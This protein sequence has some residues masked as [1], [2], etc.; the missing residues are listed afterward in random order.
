MSVPHLYTYACTCTHVCMHRYIC[1]LPIPPFFLKKHKSGKQSTFLVFRR[2]D[3]WNLCSSRK[4]QV[5]RLS[6]GGGVNHF[7]HFT[8]NGIW[9]FP[10]KRNPVMQCERPFNT[11]RLLSCFII[12]VY[13]DEF[14]KKKIP[15]SLVQSAT[16]DIALGCFLCLWVIEPCSCMGHYVLFI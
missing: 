7:G 4:F 10:E 8:L 15:K 2:K 1:T 14:N 11:A 5:L 3:L 13:L 16:L 9:P 6:L 12:L